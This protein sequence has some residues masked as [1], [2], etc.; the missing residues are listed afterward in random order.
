[1]QERNRAWIDR[2]GVAA[3]ARYEWNLD[4]A[5]IKFPSGAGSV[6]A[7]LCIIGSASEHEGTF[8][9]AWSNETLP[10]GAQRRLEDVRAFGLR[11]DLGLLTTPEWEGGRAEGLEMVAVAGRILDAEGTWVDTS[12]DLT[13]FF[14]LS[15]F[16]RAP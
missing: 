11:H 13:T 4:T 12:G 8:L 3:D 7:D 5:T 14:L 1:M 15:R 16:R 9:W 10:R 2:F 6:I